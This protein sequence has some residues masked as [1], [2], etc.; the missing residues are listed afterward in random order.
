MEGIAPAGILSGSSSHLLPLCFCG[1]AGL[2]AIFFA[3]D[4]R[5]QAL[6]GRGATGMAGMMIGR[7]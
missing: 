4:C 1:L 5:G 3:Q 2:S 7:W 6:S